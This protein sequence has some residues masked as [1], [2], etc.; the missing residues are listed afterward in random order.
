[1]MLRT[2][3]FVAGT[4]CAGALIFGA[5]TTALAANSDPGDHFSVAAGTVVKGH[6]K[7]GTNLKFTGTI[8][9]VAITVNCSTFTARGKIPAKG[10]TV[11]LSAPPTIS[12]CHD[13]LGGTDTVRTNTTNGAWKLIEVDATGTADNKEPNT[14]HGVLS[15]PKAGAKFKSSI[16]SSCTVTA[17]PNGRASIRGRYNDINTIKDTNAA[18]PTKGSG[19][20]TA[21]NAHATATVILSPK[22]HDTK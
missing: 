1:M 4:A 14:D 13:S 10:L 2:K 6:L 12:G 22:V 3:K 8:D 9:G 11:K 18:I 7:S 17:A 21:A 15:M 5:S 20:T 16:L 19:C